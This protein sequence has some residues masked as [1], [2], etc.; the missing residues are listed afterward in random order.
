MINLFNDLDENDLGTQYIN[1]GDLS[2]MCE[3]DLW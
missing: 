3:P 2:E 1:V